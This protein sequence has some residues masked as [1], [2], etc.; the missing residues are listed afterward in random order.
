[1][2]SKKQILLELKTKVAALPQFKSR[3]YICRKKFGTKFAF[4]HLEY[5]NTPTYK[6]Q[7]YKGSSLLY[8]LDLLPFIK[9]N[10]KTL[11]YFVMFTMISL[12]GLHQLRIKLCGEGS[13]KLGE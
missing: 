1:V 13:A 9:K 12:A 6:D 2:T 8:Q 3:C 10:L 7:K 5:D 11:C 4:H